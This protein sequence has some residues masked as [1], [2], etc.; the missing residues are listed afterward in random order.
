MSF[1]KLICINSAAKI[2]TV[3]DHLKKQH[4]SNA[5]ASIAFS[6]QS[7]FPELELDYLEMNDTLMK[8]KL[9][10]SA[11]I[12]VKEVELQDS[13][14]MAQLWSWINSFISSVNP[15][16]TPTGRKTP[17]ENRIERQRNIL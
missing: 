14:L 6:L 15:W 4:A 12:L 3:Q 11:T 10:P 2:R 7:T 5:N 1:Y 17:K 13:G 9:V 16:Y 8:L